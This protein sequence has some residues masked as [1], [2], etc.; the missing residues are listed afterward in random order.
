MSFLIKIL[1]FLKLKWTFGIVCFRFSGFR[2]A[3]WVSWFRIWTIV[4]AGILRR[5]AHSDFQ[6]AEL[7][8][9]KSN[10]SI[11]GS[12]RKVPAM[13]GVRYFQWAVYEIWKTENRSLFCCVGTISKMSFSKL[14][15]G[16]GGERHHLHHPSPCYRLSL[17]SF[18]PYTLAAF[19]PL[20]TP[21]FSHLIHTSEKF[22]F[23]CGKKT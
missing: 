6:T 18:C 9:F 3:S 14:N 17:K 5:T 10:K 4:S 21:L 7:N 13:T 22:W 2:R 23:S 12:L 15:R 20:F 11:S 19:S 8:I 16:R 1:V